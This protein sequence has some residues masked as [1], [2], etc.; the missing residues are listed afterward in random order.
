MVN[1]AQRHMK[2]FMLMITILLF[3][4][5]GR[6][7]LAQALDVDS[8]PALPTYRGAMDVDTFIALTDSH[9]AVP[10]QDKYMHY[11]VRLPKGWEKSKDMSSGSVLNEK[12]LTSNILGEIVRYYSPSDFYTLSR[13][14]ITAMA[15][16]RQI[17][18]KNWFLN[19]VMTN[20]YVLQGLKVISEREA[21]AL[22]VLIDGDTSYS[23]RSRVVINGRRIFIVS[24]YVPYKK[25][26][27]DPKER[28]MQEYA[29]NSFK[30]LTPAKPDTNFVQSFNYL[31]LVE[32]D[33]PSSWRLQAPRAYSSEGLDARLLSTMNKK[34]LNGEIDISI[35]S[36]KTETTIAEE[37]KKVKDKLDKYGFGLGDPV[38][39]EKTFKFNNYIYF[40]RVEAFKAPSTHDGVI[41]HE[42]W[43]AILVED[44]YINI[45]TL[46]TPN[47][48]DSFYTWS[49]NI[50]AFKDV[51][52][53]FRPVDRRKS[54][55][56]KPEPV[57]KGEELR[58]LKGRAG[59]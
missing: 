10:M 50:E 36:T 48:R 54:I 9:E 2:A 57:D 4:I 13:F 58:G 47:R 8:I 46:L 51:I 38:K 34:T 18:A 33:Y 5:S 29:I 6:Q 7:A 35:V 56:Q 59:E 45:I 52:E 53:S 43:I 21:E 23:V 12:N 17:A 41:D 14:S 16:E 39:M 40:S 11:Q 1:D 32:F 42:F 19:Y 26:S 15:M 37:L 44:R 31:D 25:W 27:E 55:L 20:G 30:F 28:A 24:Y 3:G 49:I 22:Y